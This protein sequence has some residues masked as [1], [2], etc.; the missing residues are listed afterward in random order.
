MYE[1]QKI[2]GSMKLMNKS[3]P[4]TEAW[5]FGRDLWREL[6]RRAIGNSGND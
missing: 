5:N 6:D 4:A 2:L 1:E 3:K